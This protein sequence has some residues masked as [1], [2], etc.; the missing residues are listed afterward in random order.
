VEEAAPPLLH[1]MKAAAAFGGRCTVSSS[2]S[3][4][5]LGARDGEENA[6]I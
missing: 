5:L 4:E 3:N 1:G 6:G 2:S